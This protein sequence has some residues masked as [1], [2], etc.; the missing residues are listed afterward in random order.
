MERE[1]EL[2][3]K[4]KEAFKLFKNKQ[5]FFLSGPAGVGKSYLLGVLKEYAQENY[6]QLQLTVITGNAALLINRKT[7]D[8]CAS[9][10]FG[11]DSVE[12]LL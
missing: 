10:G 5:N 7:L 3:D 1:I 4:Q 9:I 6:K 12:K 2:K 8:T 11:E